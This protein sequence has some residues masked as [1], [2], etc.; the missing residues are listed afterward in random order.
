MR[1][2]CFLCEMVV[3]V[4]ILCSVLV[5][6]LNWWIVVCEVSMGG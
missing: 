4:G 3:G 2:S 6:W 5:T 1:V